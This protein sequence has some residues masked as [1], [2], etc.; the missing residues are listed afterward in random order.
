L[1][2]ESQH[3]HHP[4]AHPKPESRRRNFLSSLLSAALFVPWAFG[5]SKSPAQVA[6]TFR[7]MSE[8][9]ELQG[10]ASP[11][12]GITTDG[13]VVPKLFQ[14]SPSGISA[15]PVRNAAEKFIATL[16]SVQ[17]VRTMFPVDDIQW[18]KWMNQHFYPRAGISFQEMT[19]VQ[20]NAAFG[21]M[22]AS[23]SAQGLRPHTEYHAP[24]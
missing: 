20:R 24:E 19:D 15:E 11:F 3:F 16:T 1:S 13:T 6:E 4:H 17:L 5:Q 9:R 2:H 23:L 7:R 18:R 22:R 21:L 10:L 14:I 8:D 12:K